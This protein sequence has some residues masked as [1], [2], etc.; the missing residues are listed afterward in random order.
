MELRNKIAAAKGRYFSFKTE[1]APL[2]YIGALRIIEEVCGDLFRRREG[3]SSLLLYS[4]EHR[5]G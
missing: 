4:P 1:R 5:G 3:P 2:Y